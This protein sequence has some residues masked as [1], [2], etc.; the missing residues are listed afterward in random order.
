M[1]AGRASEAAVDDAAHDVVM[2]PR[3]DR[4][5]RRHITLG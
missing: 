2:G 3:V 1:A 5:V 4:E